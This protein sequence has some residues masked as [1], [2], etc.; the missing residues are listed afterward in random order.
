M[1]PLKHEPGQDP[2]PAELADTIDAVRRVG[3]PALF[4][5]PQY[6]PAAAETIARETGA[7]VYTLDPVVTGSLSPDAYENAMRKNM[8][9]LIQALG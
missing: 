8:E 1:N 3:A 7:V 5:E 2:S 9:T 4:S 6:T